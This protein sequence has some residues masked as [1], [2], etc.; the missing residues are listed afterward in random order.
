MSA[1]SSEMLT[2]KFKRLAT[3]NPSDDVSSSSSRIVKRWSFQE[4]IAKLFAESL[5][6]SFPDFKKYPV[7]YAS[8]EGQDG[9]YNCQ[10]VLW[11]WPKLRKDPELQKRYLD[12]KKPTDVAMKIKENLPESAMIDG[13]ASIQ[14]VGFVAISLSRKWLAESIHK[15]L[16][17][18]I[19][20]WAPEL[21][22][23][24]VLVVDYPLIGVNVGLFQQRAIRDTLVRM[25]EFSVRKAPFSLAKSDF[26]NSYKHLQTLRYALEELK[27]NWIVYVTPKWR[28][29]YIE[30]CFTA[31]KLEGWCPTGWNGYPKTSY[32]GYQAFS[33]PKEFIS[34][35]EE[36]KSGC[37]AVAEGENAKLLG[38]TCEAVLDCVLQYT[39]L[40][41]YRLAACT[42]DVNEMLNEKENTFV[43]LLET[44]AQVHRI[45]TNFREEINELK[46][47]SELILKNNIGRGVQGKERALEFHLLEFTEVLKDSCLFVSPDMLCA[48]LHGLCKKFTQYY[49]SVHK[50]GSISETSTLLCEATALVMETG[51]HLLGI[52]PEFSNSA[53]SLQSFAK[54]EMGTHV[55]KE[56]QNR[57]KRREKRAIRKQEMPFKDFFVTYSASVA[58]DQPRNC[59]FELFSIRSTITTDSK[60]ENGKLFGLISVSDKNGLLPDAG[61]H[62]SDPDES[63]VPLFNVD[64]SKPH[65]MRNFGVVFLGDPSSRCP[66]PFSSTIGIRIELNVGTEKN[67]ACYHLCNTKFEIDLTDFWA[68]KLNS[69]CGHLSVN[70]ED[71]VTNMYYVLLKD[72]V[73][74][75]LKVRL[76][77]NTLRKVS[78]T[79]FAYYDDGSEFSMELYNP[80]Q[81]CYYALLFRAQSP[82]DLND[83]KIVLRRS[84]MAV[85]MRGALTIKANLKAETGF[86]PVIL[87]GSH[88]FKPQ[89]TSSSKHT[90]DG[91][92]GTNCALDLEVCW[93]YPDYIHMLKMSI[94]GVTV[95][96]VIQEQEQ[97]MLKN[98]L[99]LSKTG[100]TGLL[101][102]EPESSGI[103]QMRAT[104][105]Q[106]VTGTPKLPGSESGYKHPPK[107]SERAIEPVNK[108]SKRALFPDEQLDQK[109]KKT[110]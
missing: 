62:L 35:F 105:S 100:S 51:F 47:A 7:I 44:R 5:E 55:A 84:V 54:Q 31:A 21:P 6:L 66:I 69:K 65:N 79:I 86:E 73:D 30:M 17:V 45:T 28:Q 49:S 110:E 36:L 18:G 27:A 16:K 83:G 13:E 2:R 26:D 71:G 9:D 12:I 101:S 93:K 14:D 96:Q 90:I 42:F 63:Y 34:L 59:R 33:E 15:M 3:N 88:A 46:K 32:V 56:K 103:T 97:T 38:Y 94:N 76:K 61:C 57:S 109:K 108:S 104:P 107:E 22:V 102:K 91:G 99:I 39:F 106:P 37:G 68:K 43:Y 19:D 85:P 52:T 53:Q 41:N 98:E 20:T 11:I 70:G 60:F 8:Q 80:I 58:R 67:D 72:A 10:N 95:E 1:Y 29:E 82:V 78:G 74:A 75:V 89:R 4:K 23:K 87:K 64:W 81:S 77:T 92:E 25:L 50:L 24:R 40:K 48:Y